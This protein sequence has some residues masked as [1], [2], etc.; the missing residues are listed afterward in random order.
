NNGITTEDDYD[1]VITTPIPPSADL[2]LTKTVDNLTPFVGANVTFEIIVTNSGPQDATGVQVTDLL[3]SGYT[4][5]S[6][7]ST[8]G[9]YDEAAGIWYIDNL[10]NGTNE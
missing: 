3:P 5:V 2:S 1:S 4:F 9:N 6:Y 7:D 10:A 8:Y